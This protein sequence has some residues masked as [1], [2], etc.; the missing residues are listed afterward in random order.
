MNSR[1]APPVGPLD[2]SSAPPRCSIGTVDTAGV[3]SENR[4]GHVE[5]GRCYRF[6]AAGYDALPRRRRASEPPDGALLRV[7]DLNADTQCSAEAIDGTIVLVM[8]ASLQ[9]VR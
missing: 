6:H 2:E 5:V 7:L 8:V 3:P 4:A 9:E 1:F